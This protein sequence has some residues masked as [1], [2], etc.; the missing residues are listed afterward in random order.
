MSKINYKIN[1]KVK[2]NVELSLKEL[3]DL[4]CIIA[5]SDINQVDFMKVKDRRIRKMFKKSYEKRHRLWLKLTHQYQK[6]I[7]KQ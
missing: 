6:E 4:C 5:E 2:I 3:I 1:Y 7:N